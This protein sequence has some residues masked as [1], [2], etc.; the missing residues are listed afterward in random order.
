MWSRL[1]W[2]VALPKH[3][4]LL[5]WLFRA[6][7]LAVPL[8]W[9]TLA[10]LTAAN[11][12]V[13]AWAVWRI[14]TLMLSQERAAVALMLYLLAPFG[15]FGGKPAAESSRYPRYPRANNSNGLNLHFTFIFRPTLDAEQLTSRDG[16]SAQ[17]NEIWIKQH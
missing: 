2:S 14:A 7:G 6:Y 11:I 8:D 3:P 1:G 17:N 16:I 10:L 12:T 4:P 13:G 15:T 5:P 9:A